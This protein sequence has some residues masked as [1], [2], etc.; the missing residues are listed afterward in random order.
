MMAG[1][2]ALG[3]N[4]P[5]LCDSSA[6]L[7]PSLKDLR[8]VAREIAFAVAIEAQHAG[9]AQPTT[10]EELRDRIAATQWTPEYQNLVRAMP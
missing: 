5:A 1:G 3:E 7:L 4:S 2:R 9:V 8:R 10:P 6:T